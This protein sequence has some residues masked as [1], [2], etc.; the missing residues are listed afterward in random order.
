MPAGHLQVVLCALE[1]ASRRAELVGYVEPEQAPLAH[2][3]R[4]VQSSGRSHDGQLQLPPPCDGSQSWPW[5][6]MQA[7]AQEENA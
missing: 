6:S 5:L 2:A 1:F 4:I 3:P 7:E